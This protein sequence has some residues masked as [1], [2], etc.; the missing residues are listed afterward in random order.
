MTEM[1]VDM[2]N[3]KQAAM[4]LNGL[5]RLR[6]VYRF[7]FV[8]F[9]PRRSDRQ[10]RYYWPCFVKPFA[11][12]LRDQGETTTDDEAHELLKYKF[13]RRSKVNPT[14]GEVIEYV[15]STTSLDTAEFNEYLDQCAAW[16]ADMFGIIVPEP[17]AYHEKD[18]EQ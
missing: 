3:A 7:E 16:L 17:E 6:G 15:A 11:D 5:R 9:R 14:T 2:S 8:K 1:T 13:L 12:F 10:N 18:S 4:F